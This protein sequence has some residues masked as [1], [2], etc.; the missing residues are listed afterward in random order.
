VNGLTQI[1]GMVGPAEGAGQPGGAEDERQD[2][3]VELAHL[4]IGLHECP[5]AP[6]DLGQGL[7]DLGPGAAE[8]FDVGMRPGRSCTGRGCAN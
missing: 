2:L 8:D 5:R 1:L 6:L 7:Q 4:R 3:A